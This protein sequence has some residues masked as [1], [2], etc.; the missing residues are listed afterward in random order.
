M[1]IFSS[2]IPSALCKWNQDFLVSFF[3]FI[4]S[5]LERQRF[6]HCCTLLTIN[7]QTL[8][9]KL[10]LT[11]YGSFDRPPPQL[12]RNTYDHYSGLGQYIL[13]FYANIINCL[14][15]SKLACRP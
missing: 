8:G 1:L 13:T 3:Y 5:D 6:S 12:V 7:A 4:W 9:M 11:L 14:L 15:H 2:T 10:G